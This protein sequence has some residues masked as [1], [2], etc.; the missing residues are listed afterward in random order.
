[1][2]G[3]DR[4]RTTA[5]TS[6]RRWRPGRSNLRLLGLGVT[7]LLMLSAIVVKVGLLQT[8]DRPAL[9]AVGEQQRIDKVRLTAGRGVVFDRNLHELAMSVPQTSVWAD[10][11]LVKDKEAT[12]TALADVLG[13]DRAAI[14]ASLSSNAEFAWIARQVDDD[15]ATQLKAMKMDGVFF[16]TEPKR[17]WPA[18]DLARGVLGQ[19]DVDGRGISGIE[20][21]F[22][23]RLTGTTGSLIRERDGQ[24]NS[25]PGGLHQL[26]PAEPG[27]DLVLSVDRNLQYAVEQMLIDHVANLHAKG[28]MVVV[29]RP[30]TGEIL[31]IANVVTPPASAGA[32]APKPVVS[33]ANMAL[34][35]VFEPGSVNK[36][37][38]AAA[39]LDTGAVDPTTVLPV[40]DKLSLAKDAQ[41]SDADPHALAHWNLSDIVTQSSNIGTILVA[42]RMQRTQLDQYL[43]AFGLGSRTALNFPNESGGILPAVSTWTK[44]SMGS[45]PIGQGVAVTA[46]QML[47]AT[48]VIA[49]GGT[50]VAPTLLEATINP[51]G[52]RVAAPAPERHPVVSS[53][54]AALV[55]QMLERVVTDGT[56]KNAAIAGYSVAGKTGTARKPQANGTYQDAAGNYHYVSSFA[57]YAPAEAP[58]ISAIVVIDEPPPTGGSEA[59]FAGQVAAPLFSKVVTEALRELQIP[60]YPTGPAA[61][62]PTPGG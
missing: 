47:E 31:A 29:T 28:G 13:R 16:L 36:I 40:P 6:A 61:S 3:P 23:G 10:P 21:A 54:T 32:P 33:S 44:S 60:P 50:Y 11:R 43:R 49:D 24:G 38:T 34:V 25:I 14:V 18:D 55:S 59:Y 22:D 41:Y 2:A 48:N 4:R 7:T 62:T 37:I 35:D 9:Q 42:S 20:A 1:M 19:T 12:G 57:G 39:A 51:D 8:V 15:V 58:R 52:T 45:I 56:G 53:R 46:L 30:D 26:R 27:S 5:R 17:F